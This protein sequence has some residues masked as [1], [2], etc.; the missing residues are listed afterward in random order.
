MMSGRRQR[1]DGTREWFVEFYSGYSMKTKSTRTNK[2]VIT[3]SVRNSSSLIRNAGRMDNLGLNGA[4]SNFA[5]KK[6][7]TS[8]S[9]STKNGCFSISIKEQTQSFPTFG[10]R[11][12]ATLSKKS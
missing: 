3:Q 2:P 1:V 8:S 11:N 7:T 6:I 10:R 9:T 12:Y 5:K 4:R